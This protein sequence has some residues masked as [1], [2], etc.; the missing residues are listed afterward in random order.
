MRRARGATWCRYSTN[1]EIGRANTHAAQR[2][3]HL[4]AAVASA[5]LPIMDS[6][7][8][9]QCFRPA[10]AGYRPPGRESPEE[11]QGLRYLGLLLRRPLSKALRSY[12]L[13][14][15]NGPASPE[16]RYDSLDAAVTWSAQFYHG[17]PST[18]LLTT[19]KACVSREGYLSGIRSGNRAAAAG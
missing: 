8:D 6:L 4:Q 19:R 10:P 14:A 3:V 9:T 16:S 2:P 18:A 11:C 17:T 12:F 7:I 13:Q 1:S 15:R 5:M